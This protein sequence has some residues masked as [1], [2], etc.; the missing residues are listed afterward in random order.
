M[1]AN[2]IG[3]TLYAGKAL[4]QQKPAPRAPRAPRPHLPQIPDGLTRAEISEILATTL[5]GSAEFL[6]TLASDPE[7]SRS[8]AHVATIARNL[9]T[10]ADILDGGAD[11]LAGADE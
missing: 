3:P 8:P 5:A 1:S 11:A 10:L 2:A 9:R 7:I 4:A 6:A